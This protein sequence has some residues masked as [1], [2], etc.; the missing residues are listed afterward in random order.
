LG[1]ARHQ[2]PELCLTRST[3]NHAVADL[4]NEQQ[5]VVDK[6]LRALDRQATKIEALMAENAA[7]KK[8]LASATPVR[9]T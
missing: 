9:G 3:W 8:Q 6:L 4:A 2:G 5:L 7:L 1:Q